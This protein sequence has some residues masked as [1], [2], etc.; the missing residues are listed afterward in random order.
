MPHPSPEPMHVGPLWLSSTDPPDHAGHLESLEA[1]KAE[2][3]AAIEDKVK[4][5]TALFLEMEDQLSTE[6]TKF[7]RVLSDFTTKRIEQISERYNDAVCEKE[8]RER[9][10]LNPSSFPRSPLTPQTKLPPESQ[11][12]KTPCPPP[13]QRM[14]A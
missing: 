11:P 14:A 3:S 1:T 8:R 7:L 12:S 9:C 4:A 13:E 10:S 6:Q 5:L 2:R